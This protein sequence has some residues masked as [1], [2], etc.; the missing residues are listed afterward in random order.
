[1]RKQPNNLISKRVYIY[2]K[3]EIKEKKA[4]LLI[5]TS[6]TVLQLL[7]VQA[8]QKL[9]T[10]TEKTKINI[11]YNDYNITY[12]SSS[13]WLLDNIE[14][15]TTLH[16]NLPH[17]G[18]R[19]SETFT[20]IVYCN[21]LVNPFSLH[22]KVVHDGD[23]EFEIF[24]SVTINMKDGEIEMIYQGDLPLNNGKINAL[25]HIKSDFSTKL[26]MTGQINQSNFKMIL[27]TTWNSFTFT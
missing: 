16:T 20:K 15:N 9:L 21:N 24:S 12:N 25:L 19:K 4:N 11:L 10:N 8:A 2:V 22:Y 18:F 7:Q 1:M 5:E 14:S 26:E 13:S 3:I 27:A 17:F 23:K 6:F